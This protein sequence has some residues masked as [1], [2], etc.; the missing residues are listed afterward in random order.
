LPE[1]MSLITAPS[2]FH[3][4]LVLLPIALNEVC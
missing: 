2:M 1:A 3:C 4:W